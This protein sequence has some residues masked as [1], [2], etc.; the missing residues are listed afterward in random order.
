MKFPE[1]N[2]SP[3]LRVLLC[4]AWFSAQGGDG[5]SGR[6]EGTEGGDG[7]RGRRE[8]TEGGDGGNKQ[9]PRKAPEQKTLVTVGSCCYQCPP[10]E[11]L[12]AGT[13]NS[14]CLLLLSPGGIP[15]GGREVGR[16]EGTEGGDG[17]S[18]RREGTEVKKTHERRRNSFC[19]FGAQERPP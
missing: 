1:I 10:A 11:V 15:S 3:C 7:G 14:S 17:G 8:G 9:N 4:Y 2:C 18:G 6:R 19:S 16:R 13:S 5:G 12:A